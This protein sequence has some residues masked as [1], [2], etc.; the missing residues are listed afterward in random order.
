MDNDKEYLQE[1]NIISF[2]LLLN[3]LMSLNYNE[4]KT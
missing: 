1:I 2:T 3:I 4:Q